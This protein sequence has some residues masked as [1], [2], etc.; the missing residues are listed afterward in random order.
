MRKANGFC[1]RVL[2]WLRGG[3]RPMA[4]TVREGRYIYAD[5]A[6]NNN[7]FWNIEELSNGSCKLHWGRVGSSGQRQVISFASSPQAASFFDEKCREKES[8]GYQRLKV[9]NGSG[10]LV[11]AAP[12]QEVAAIAAQQIETDSPQTLA[13]VKRLADA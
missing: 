11:N 6:R 13:L 7:K 3:A 4:S 8:K 9:L 5:V 2:N 12:S 1:S 10:V